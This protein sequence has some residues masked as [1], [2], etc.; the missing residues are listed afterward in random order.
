MYSFDPE[1]LIQVH[2]IFYKTPG[3]HTGRGCLIEGLKLSFSSF[4]AENKECVRYYA[5]RKTKISRRGK[6]RRW[7]TASVPPFTNFRKIARAQ[8][9]RDSP[10]HKGTSPLNGIFTRTLVFNRK[11]AVGRGELY[12]FAKETVPRENNRTPT[13]QA[14]DR[15]AALQNLRAR[16][17]ER[18]QSDGH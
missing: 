11:S 10:R 17:H 14:G 4:I 15:T 5:G 1:K 6:Q 9:S 3:V 18:T 7:D 13:N 16:F 2:S 12:A 8:V